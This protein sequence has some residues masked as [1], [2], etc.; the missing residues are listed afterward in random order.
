MTSEQRNE[1]AR[2]FDAQRSGST[3]PLLKGFRRLLISAIHYLDLL[4][5]RLA[6]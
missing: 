4:E 2:G 1:T 5:E 3:L 6:R